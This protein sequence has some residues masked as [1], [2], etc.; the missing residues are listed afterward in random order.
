MAQ[1]PGGSDHPA[2][3]DSSADAIDAGVDAGP[4][5][6]GPVTEVDPRSGWEM[7]AETAVT[8]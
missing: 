2:A 6:T 5:D 3:I 8:T 1:P 4:I 7:A